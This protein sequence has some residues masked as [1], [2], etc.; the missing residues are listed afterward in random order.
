MS[1]FQQSPT[2]IFLHIPKTAGTTLTSICRRQYNNDEFCYIDSQPEIYGLSAERKEKI[3]F[4]QGSYWFGIHEELSRP[5]TYICLLRD[6]LKRIISLYDYTRQRKGH[7]MYPVTIE[8]T[9]TEIYEK[10]LHKEALDNGQTRRVSGIWDGVPYGGV[11]EELFEQAKHNLETKFS[12]V[13]T[14][15]RFDETLLLLKK[16]FGWHDIYYQ[17]RNTA[18]DNKVDKAVITERDKELILQHNKWD[19]KLHEFAGELLNKSVVDYGPNYSK[20]LAAFH[21]GNRWIRPVH[22]FYWG[23]IRKVS[24]RTMA[25]SLLSYIR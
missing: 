10:G 23:V 17:R 15:E 21:R 8:N 24:V 12:V 22:Q 3:R 20:D 18:K 11:T 2:A 14:T 5:Y 9:I 25:K 4:L 1:R 13:G 19:Q 16:E 6:P 7:N